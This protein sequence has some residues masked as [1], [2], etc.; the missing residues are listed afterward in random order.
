MQIDSI[1][2]DSGALGGNAV[3]VGLNFGTA[4]KVVVQISNVADLLASGI[5]DPAR[6]L[7]IAENVA[8]VV[9]NLDT[10]AW[11]RS[12]KIP[13][14]VSARVSDEGTLWGCTGRRWL[15]RRGNG[16]AYA[17]RPLTGR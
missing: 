14:A 16:M 7:D 10:P 1:S 6:W 13:Y 2:D 3:T 12:I 11:C 15:A 5:C 17:P 4:T 8:P 9:P